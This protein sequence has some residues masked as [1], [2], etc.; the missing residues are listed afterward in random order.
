MFQV[1]ALCSVAIGHQCFKGSCCLHL[2]GGVAGARKKGQTYRPG[3]QER[4]RSFDNQCC[5]W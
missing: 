1:E 3:V 2:Q 4:K 5:Q